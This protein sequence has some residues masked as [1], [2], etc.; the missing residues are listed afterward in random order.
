MDL[1]P[2]FSI[3]YMYRIVLLNVLFNL[4]MHFKH[5]FYFLHFKLL[6]TK[7]YTTEGIKTSVCISKGLFSVLFNLKTEF[8]KML[9]WNLKTFY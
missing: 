8:L 9:F 3:I 2:T 7:T 1:N 6:I 4:L 5:L